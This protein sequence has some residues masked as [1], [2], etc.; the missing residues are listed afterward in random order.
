MKAR[1]FSVLPRALSLITL[2]ALVPLAWGVS[3]LL[4]GRGGQ[5]TPAH[6]QEGALEQ[7]EQKKGAELSR[8]P[9]AVFLPRMA[10]RSEGRTLHSGLRLERSASAWSVSRSTFREGG[11]ATGMEL[12]EHLGGGF[13]F[14]Q[15]LSVAGSSATVLYRAESWTGELQPLGSVPF[16]VQQV[17]AGFDRLYLFGTALQIA[18]DASTGELLPLDPLPPVVSVENLAFS[19]TQALLQA[20]L[21]GVLWTPDS[22]LS[23]RKLSAAVGI[24]SA[25]EGLRVQTR[26][27]ERVLALDGSL[28]AVKAPARRSPREGSR[29][30][31]RA[32]A[33]E[34]SH[35][36]EE[37]DLVSVLTTGLA[38][39]DRVQRDEAARSAPFRALGATSKGAA[40]RRWLAL[41]HGRQ[42]WVELRGEQAEGG[43]S[44]L[45]F[46]RERIADGRVPQGACL[47]T[48]SP[49]E[50]ALFLC[51]EAPPQDAAA[52]PGAAAPPAAAVK[53]P[54]GRAQRLVQW[55]ADGPTTRAQIRGTSL[56]ARG[57]GAFLVTGDCQSARSDAV[58]W[59]TSRGARAVALGALEASGKRGRLALAVSRNS[60]HAVTWQVDDNELVRHALPFPAAGEVAS[61]DRPKERIRYPF[62]EI[63]EL[64]QWA[65]QA[66]LVQAGGRREG[67][68]NLWITAGERFVGAL[69]SDDGALNFGAQ[70]RP[71]ARALL[72]GPRALVW[73]AAGFA[74]QSTDGGLTFSEVRIP[75]RSGDA[76][77]ADPLSEI[78]EVEMGCGVVGCVLGPWLRW[79]WSEEVLEEAA[80]PPARPLPP[81]GGGRAR[82]SCGQGDVV[83]PRR[84][85]PVDAGFPSFWE[86]AAPQLPMRQSGFSIGFSHDTARLYAMGP[87]ASA[88]PNAGRLQLRFIDPYDPAR[89]RETRPTIHVVDDR[90][91]AETLLGVLD[92]TT[93]RSELSLTA[94]AE[95]GLFFLRT[96]GEEGLFRFQADGALSRVPLEDQRTGAELSVSGLAGTVLSEGRWFFAF[97]EGR[98]SFVVAEARADGVSVLARLPWGEASARGA[99]LVGTEEGHLGVAIEGDRG[100]LVYPLSREGELGDPLLV[101]HSATR[102]PS[103]ERESRGFLVDREYSLTPYLETPSGRPLSTSGL[104]ALIRVGGAGPC[105]EGL[106]ARSRSVIEVSEPLPQMTADRVPL[107]LL[108]SDSAG[109]RVRLFCQ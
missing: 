102:P 98:S 22:G 19:R 64:R 5:P 76:G 21:V 32:S 74:K 9:S 89:I 81:Q 96:R 42:T 109:N 20:P 1:L 48:D 50:G 86:S 63:S 58:C 30:R 49:P 104:R 91:Q 67:V 72:D 57:E 13:L 92:R 8:K 26:A 80:I 39:G 60:L 65:Q 53:V 73:G 88:W 23:W 85:A 105:L 33:P 52:P 93:S 4:V 106:T 78:T 97:S 107:T 47:G 61:F 35:H 71:L 87:E 31:Q 95:A 36:L 6:G 40:P 44:G 90:V 46:R 68:T 66:T 77:L 17:H 79:G 62:E 15:S 55:R 14:F 2:R 100:L 27:G 51:E 37:A 101:P 45:T 56:R 38:V 41:G 94:E 83:T 10:P 84:R 82:F 24:A 69:L 59:V 99:A 3:V 18:L 34:V 54:K 103:C 11:E 12:P 43:N 75:F 7:G 16:S 25:G 108:S 29:V 28:E 70:Q